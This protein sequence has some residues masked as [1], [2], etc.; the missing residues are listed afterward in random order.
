[1][2]LRHVYAVE[3]ICLF[4]ETLHHQPHLSANSKIKKSSSEGLLLGV[5]RY[6]VHI[7]PLAVNKGHKFSICLELGW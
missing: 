2:E 3:R 4:S 7:L 1:M 6:H 5:N